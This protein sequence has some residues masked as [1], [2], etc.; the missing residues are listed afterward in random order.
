MDAVFLNNHR[1]KKRE[2]FFVE[3]F[4]DKCF[5]ERFHLL[6]LIK[7]NTIFFEFR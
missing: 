4:F 2:D 6:T 1:L 3:I 5:M 7:N